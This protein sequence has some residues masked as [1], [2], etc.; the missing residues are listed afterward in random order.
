MMNTKYVVWLILILFL[1]CSMQQKTTHIKYRTIIGNTPIKINMKIPQGY[2]EK[3]LER[4]N[5]LEKQFWYPD[6]SVIYITASES[7]LINYEKIRATGK[8]G[9]R[10][11]LYD[12]LTLNGF[13][14]DSLY[15]KDIKIKTGGSIGYANVTKDQKEKFEKALESIVQK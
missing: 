13:S 10:Q 6:S 11:F 1:G 15:W 9:D 4:G 8:S 3:V 14:E 2:N 12:T 7:P 5:E